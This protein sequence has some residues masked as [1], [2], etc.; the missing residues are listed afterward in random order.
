MITYDGKVY[1]GMG[2]GY[3]FADPAPLKAEHETIVAPEFSS[4]TILAVLMAL[5]MLAATLTKKNRT[6]RFC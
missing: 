3:I 1:V 2:N 5:T 6:R 4:N